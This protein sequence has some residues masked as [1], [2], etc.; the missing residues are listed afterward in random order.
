MSSDLQSMLRNLNWP[1]KNI[2]RMLEAGHG[3]EVL[4]NFQSLNRTENINLLNALAFMYGR[5]SD[6]FPCH[7][8]AKVNIIL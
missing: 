1:S 4:K 8:M 3:H 5:R 2:A 7:V 6:G